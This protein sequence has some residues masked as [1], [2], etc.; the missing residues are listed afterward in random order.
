MLDRAYSVLT[1]KSVHADQRVITGIATTPTP[2]RMG[3]ILEPLGVTYTNPLPLLFH[4]DPTQPVGTVT[5]DPPTRKGITFTASIPLITEPGRVRDRVEEA[6]QSVKAGLIRGMSVGLQPLETK[7]HKSGGR[8]LHIVKS[9]IAELS[10]VT[11]PANI[12]ATVL[13]VKSAVTG[14]QRIPM[15]AGEHV[16]ALEN[17]RAAL[18]AR[19]GEIM[20]TA[21]EAS[22]TTDETQA[23]EHDGLSLQVK[24]ID[25]DL[26]RWRELEQLQM[27]QAA[28]VAPV[29]KGA[30]LPAWAPRVISVK[31]SV[32][33]GTAFV[34]MA[35]SLMTCHGNKHEAAAYASRWEDS[36]PEVALALKAA[37]APGTTTDAA[38]AA[39]LVN[40]AI[41]NEFLELLRPATILG[42]IENL[43]EVPLNTKVP[44]QTAGG[45]YGWV[46]ETKPKPVTK[47]AFATETLGVAKAAGIIVLTEELVRLSNPK[48]EEICRRDMI[49]GIA[50][51][52]DQQFIDPAVAAVAGVNPAS[53]TNGA[54]TGVATTNPV[55]DILGLINHFATNNIS[56][57]G[58]TFILSA[59]NA[60]SLSFRTNLDGSPEF[61]GIGINGGTYKG[62]K[63][64]TSN[65]AGTNVVALQPQLILFAD[66]GGVTID[67]S[68]EASL[69]MDSAP[70]SPADATTVYVSLWQ[71]NCVGLR[72]E[73][74]VN[75]KRVGTNA[76]KYLT[77]TAW[78]AP[79][80]GVGML[81]TEPAHVT[82][83]R[84]KASS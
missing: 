1:I 28:P 5:F 53:I 2:D 16:T 13:T 59:A 79:A 74:F 36:T 64:I 47:L 40:Q 17:K 68:R 58:V 29:V 19:M 67:A 51:F 55:A 52:L 84:T 70:A 57:D 48:A 44:A 6:W 69:Q 43:R 61:P 37:V 22:E 71:T 50:Q 26:V 45:T 42:K 12:E 23:T 82:N 32:P 63:F 39:P 80:G 78:P 65:T 24:K 75:W 54:A 38:W 14:Q 62:L 18:T 46:G 31:P 72:A 10:L 3:D 15:T 7:P 60:L 20:Q 25:G 34:R 35:C 9:L 77:A 8:G 27:H 33:I 56:V 83:G 30:P 41:A 66:D 11:I 73:R 81:S 76:V 4:H 49:A 21:A